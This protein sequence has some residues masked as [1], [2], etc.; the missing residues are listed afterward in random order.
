MK[1]YP[2]KK[3]AMTLAQCSVQSEAFEK[4]RWISSDE[5]FTEEERMKVMKLRDEVTEILISSDGKMWHDILVSIHSVLCPSLNIGFK[6]QD[7]IES[8]CKQC[9][10]VFKHKVIPG[11]TDV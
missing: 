5:D 7:K 2:I 9:G 4:W 3:V 10:I 1:K 11:Y 8:A 6:F